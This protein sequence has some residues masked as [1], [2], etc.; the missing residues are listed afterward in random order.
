MTAMKTTTAAADATPGAPSSAAP[1]A[2]DPLSPGSASRPTPRPDV[3][4]ADADA[5]Q[6]ADRVLRVTLVLDTADTD[7]PTAGWIEPMLDRAID[8]GGGANGVEAQLTVVLVDDERMAALHQQ[9]TNVPGTTDVLTFDHRDDPAD[10]DAA[11]HG[12]IVI[13]R[14]VAQREAAARGHDARVE[15]LLYAVHGLLH[16]LG[17]DDH[18]PD[19]Y[20]RMHQREDLLLEQLGVGAVFHQSDIRTHRPE[21]GPASEGGAQ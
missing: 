6:D 16:L 20:Q 8:L 18:D 17:E 4:P 21:T 7:P 12:D 19:A 5:T 14:D 10:A 1:E 2:D 13:C 3:A 11:L 9:Y 15:L